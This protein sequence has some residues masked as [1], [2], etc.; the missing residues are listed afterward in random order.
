MSSF[1]RER[2]FYEIAMSIG[3]SL[4]LEVMLKQGLSTYLRKINGLAGAVLQSRK[5]ES[6]R[7]SFDVVY[8]I[9]R[10]MRRNSAVQH[11]L[12]RIPSGLDEAE[13]KA[14][15]AELPKQDG[16]GEYKRYLMD[17]PGF[18]L[19]LLIKSAPGLS[20]PELKS[21]APLNAKLASACSYCVS[22]TRLQ[23][24]IKERKAAEENYHSIY[25][26]AVCGIFR[27]TLDGR[28]LTANPAMAQLLGYDSLEQ[29][30]VELTNVEKHFYVNL[31]DRK[32]YLA[33]LK[34]YGKVSGF[35]VEF[36]RRDGSRAWASLSAR[37]AKDE[38]TGNLFVEGMAE[39]ITL[40]RQ[41]L[42]TLREAKREA[43]RLSQLKSNFISMVSHE[44]RTPLT[45]ILGFTRI[46]DK[47]IR[48]VVGHA[49]AC[50]PDVLPRLERLMDNNEIVIA[51]GKRLAELINNVLDLSKLESGWFEWSMGEVPMTEMLRHS[52]KATG[53]LF[54]DKGL[55]LHQD[56]PDDLPVVTGDRDRLIQVVINLLSNAVKFTP[57]GSVSIVASVENGKVLVKV[58]DTG[59]GVPKEEENIIFD[60][61]RQLGNVLTDKPK[62]TGLGLPISLEIIQHHGG[63][64]WYEPNEGG[65]SVFCFT[66]PVERPSSGVC[67]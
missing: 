61:F 63:E 64:L 51:E 13:L 31:E 4:D 50:P 18:G 56:V 36:Y 49:N 6:G 55:P 5:D 48:E 24:E 3:N 45:S 29:M 53:V 59:M 33:R 47:R 2:I 60:K 19:L 44:L 30:S 43:E 8:A 66:I 37:L 15:L 16:A 21:L 10:R 28:P 57:E 34:K 11:G 58:F 39:D 22:N 1:T 7:T 14:F 20:L 41:A 32:R 42:D 9:P 52:I 62:G 12:D 40:R 65:G 46:A 17:L 27:N 67:L 38:E 35:E 23:Q 54:S 26:N 25:K